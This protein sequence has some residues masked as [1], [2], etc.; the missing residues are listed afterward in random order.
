M[1]KKG[2]G[3]SL[4]TIIVAII[5]LVVLVV[6]I[7]IFTGYF[8]PWSK[9]V[10]ACS[11]QNGMCLDKGSSGLCTDIATETNDATPMSGR[12]YGADGKLDSAKI[13]CPIGTKAKG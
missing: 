9:N 5:V 1:F 4:N 2:Q 7:L 8:S 13:C 11:T 3:M 10:G 12:C 6:L